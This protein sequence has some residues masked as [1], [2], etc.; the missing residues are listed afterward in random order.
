MKTGPLL[1]KILDSPISMDSCIVQW[2]WS[3]VQVKCF[4]VIGHDSLS[5]FTQ[6]QMDK[7]PS[8]QVI[9]WISSSQKYRERSLSLMPACSFCFLLKLHMAPVGWWVA[10]VFTL[11]GGSLFYWTR[12][13]N[14]HWV[15]RVQTRHI[16]PDNFQV[17]CTSTKYIYGW[18]FAHTTNETKLRPCRQYGP[19][20][21]S[22]RVIT[23]NCDK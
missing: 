20:G 4:Y 5:Q 9:K 2:C 16:P 18:V 17:F 15:L 1:L 12:C 11:P 19:R 8:M 3:F 10:L 14:H 21:L 13:T 23:S 7:C 22:Y 6:G